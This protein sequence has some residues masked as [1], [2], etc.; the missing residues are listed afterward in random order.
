LALRAQEYWVLLSGAAGQLYGNEYTWPFVPGWQDHLDT[1]GSVQMTYVK[2]LFE[3]RAWYNLVPDQ[4]HTLVTDGVGVIDDVD[5][6]AVA[7]TLDGTLVMAYV[8]S[9]RPVTVDMSQLSGSVTASW[10]DPPA[11]TFAAIAGSPAPNSGVLMFTAPGS[12]ADGDQDS[13]LV[14]EASQTQRVSAIT[15]NPIDLAA[16]PNSFTISGGSF[17]RQGAALPEVNFVGRGVLVGQARENGLPGG[18]RGE[19]LRHCRTG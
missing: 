12:N 9:I 5:Y 6:A 17:V 10:Y 19:R 1:P 7:R 14:L 13:V 8:P 2:A 16:A 3:P 11:G 15:P 4:G 18:R